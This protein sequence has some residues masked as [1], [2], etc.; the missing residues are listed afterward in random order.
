[1]VYPRK[2]ACGSARPFAQLFKTL[3][4]SHEA[5]IVN[6]PLT[7]R[8]LFYRD[9]ALF[10][11]QRVVDQLVDDVAASFRLERHEMN[12]RASSKGLVCG[13]GLTIS[14]RRGHDVHVNASG[15]TLIPVI[16]DVNFYSVSEDVRWVLVVEKEA[17]FNVLCQLDF[18]NRA[19]L[20][21]RG[22]LITG[23]GYPDMA[24][25]YLVNNLANSLPPSVPLLALVDG[26]PYGLD[27]LSVYKYGSQSLKH[28]NKRLSAER[29]KGLGLWT[30]DIRELGIDL[31]AML[32]L[33]VRDEQKALAMLRTKILPNKWKHE[34]MRMIYTRR[35]AEIEIILT[36]PR[37]S[38]LGE[39]AP[40]VQLDHSP[41]FTYLV[42]RIS[43]AVCRQQ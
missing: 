36:I 42:E 18:I 16:E 1:M 8:E 24:T 3:D 40:L 9:V 2:A 10:K 13:E 19:V 7:K 25:R 31:G 41:F 6:E 14:L 43:R 20:P 35:K 15:G 22:L 5:L 4:L 29:I 34:L 23:K 17:V 21:G 12:I 30:S 38:E 39:S 37:T 32:P 28:E 26:D 27:I 33:T 11:S